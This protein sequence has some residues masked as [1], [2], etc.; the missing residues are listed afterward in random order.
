MTQE[1]Y[2]KLLSIAHEMEEVLAEFKLMLRKADM[3]STKIRHDYED[4]NMDS[5]KLIKDL[6]GMKDEK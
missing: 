2:N 1:E 5:H 4:L 3:Q 6:E